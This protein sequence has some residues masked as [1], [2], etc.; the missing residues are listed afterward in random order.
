MFG[1]ALL[2]VYVFLPAFQHFDHLAWGRGSWSLCLSC[3]CLLAIHTLVCVTFSL[4]PGVGVWLRLLLVA[5]PG[6]FC[7]L[8]YIVEHIN[9]FQHLPVI[10]P[11]FSLT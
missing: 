8:F 4:P 10:I 7:L 3:M 2:F 9:C 6:R 5:L 1:L 11:F